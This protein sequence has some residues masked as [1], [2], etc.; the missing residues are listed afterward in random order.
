MSNSSHDFMGLFGSMP[1]SATQS[2]GGATN[3]SAVFGLCVNFGCHTKNSCLKHHKCDTDFLC[4]K[5]GAAAPAAWQNV[6]QKA[7]T[8]YIPHSALLMAGPVFSGRED[9]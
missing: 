7:N 8:P 2:L 6:G 9:G 4:H 3:I 5:C 1:P